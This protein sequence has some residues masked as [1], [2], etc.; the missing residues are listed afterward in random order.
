MP[1]YMNIGYS[2]CIDNLL[3]YCSNNRTCSG[4]TERI[5]QERLGVTQIMGT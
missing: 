4:D 3:S 1:L 2:T 5:L